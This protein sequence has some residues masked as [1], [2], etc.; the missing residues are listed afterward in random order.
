MA[1]LAELGSARQRNRKWTRGAL[2][3]KALVLS[4]DGGA[5]QARGTESGHGKKA[6]GKRRALELRAWE[7]GS[8]LCGMW[9][10]WNENERGPRFIKQLSS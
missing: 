1:A 5:G 9:R 10:K 6:R 8:R 2:D 4:A 7:K 3:V